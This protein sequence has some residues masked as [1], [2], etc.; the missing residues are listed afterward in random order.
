MTWLLLFATTALVL[1]LPMIPAFLEWRRPSDVAPLPI[2][3]TDALDPTWRARSAA[4]RLFVALA[5]GRTALGD[6][7]IAHVDL[8]GA[9]PLDRDERKS[10]DSLRIWHATG[11]AVLPAKTR[12]L[13]AVFAR[14]D[15]KTA[16]SGTHGALWARGRMTLGE[17]TTVIRWAHAHAVEVGRDAD[18]RGRV[19]ADEAIRVRAGTRFSLLQAPEIAFEAS[20][21]EAVASR[22]GQAAAAVVRGLPD[23]VATDHL[24]R[25][26]VASGALDVPS[27]RAWSTDL[28]CHGDLA[29]GARCHAGG[30]VKAR[31]GIAIAPRSLVDGTLVAAGT[32]VL[33]EGC[34]VLGSVVSEEAVVLRPGCRIGTPDR[35]ATVSAPRIEIAADVIVHGTVWAGESGVVVDSGPPT[36]LPVVEAAATSPLLIEVLLGHGERSPQPLAA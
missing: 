15:L 19:T 23:T 2:D 6:R 9:W 28:V 35:P 4:E 27:D 5:G 12:F 13:A 3:T 24:C 1:A 30:D 22:A 16:F 20:P 11:D 21:R 18:L 34:E 32:I 14:G 31:G 36:R 10:G 8:G 26:S 33:D 17:S 25:R 7:R 29:L